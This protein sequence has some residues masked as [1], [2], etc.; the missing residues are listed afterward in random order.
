MQNEIARDRAGRSRVLN[1]S[2][3]GVHMPF[4][5]KPPRQGL[6]FPLALADSGSLRYLSS[7]MSN[8][9]HAEF[10]SFLERADGHLLSP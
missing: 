3:G 9:S 4:V 1:P 6:P 5:P 10:D 7:L 2:I 8:L